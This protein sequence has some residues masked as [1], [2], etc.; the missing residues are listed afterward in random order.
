MIE[1]I[2]RIA[3]LQPQYS[4][5]NT[6]EM[7]RRGILIRKALPDALRREYWNVFS[8]CIGPLY[9]R[10]LKVEGKDGIGRKTQAPW[11]RIFS[12][13]LSPSATTGFYLVM[14]FST[15]GKSCFV[16]IGCGASR[17]DS[18]KGDLVEHS[19]VEIKSKVDWALGIF[20]RTGMST[21]Y[22]SDKI[23]IGSNYSLPKSFEK[24]TVLCK[25]H[26]LTT[27]NEE[28]LVESISYTLKL[29]AV[30]YDHCS[31]LS[32]LPQSEII[33]SEIQNIVDPIRKNP[34]FRQGYGLSGIERKAVELRAMVVT[35]EHLSKL[36]YKLQD[37]SLNKPFDYL[38][39]L[40]EE[41]IKV[42]V[43]GTTSEMV[44]SIM[45]TSNEVNLHTIEAGTTALAIV[46]GIKFVERGDSA[47]CDG[48]EIEYLYP[49]DIE[50][51]TISPTAFL[52]SRL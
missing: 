9:S 42:E 27:I 32:D 20:S 3:E 47:K 14:H 16:T 45:M 40:G 36:G 25:R 7:Q 31:Q 52:V 30:L 35:Y 19:D 44:D 34:N 39:I 24:A 43:K 50:K 2:K 15:D 23:D 18:E 29:L 41:T 11:V 1:E 13:S 5:K 22:L 17:W 38:A 26:E 12:E 28:E 33:R 51:W 21:S 46:R 10:D 4:S 37:T 6:P 49:W 48:G 8:E